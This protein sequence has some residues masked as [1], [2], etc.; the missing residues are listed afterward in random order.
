MNVH[1]TIYGRLSLVLL[2][3]LILAVLVP[4]GATLAR[5][6][7][8]YHLTTLPVHE[9]SL[10][11]AGTSA[12]GSYVLTRIETRIS[13]TLSRAGTYALAPVTSTELQGNICVH[14]PIVMR[15]R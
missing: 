5:S 14:L 7:P 6:G 10:S 4:I 3:G 13:S 11:G 15:N 1:R 8:D 2:A 9:E 12:G